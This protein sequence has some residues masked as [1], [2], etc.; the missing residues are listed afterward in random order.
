MSVAPRKRQSATKMRP[1]VKGPGADSCIAANDVRGCNTLFDHL[2]GKGEQ[3]V[4]HGKAERL[5][6]LEV[7]HQLELDWGLDG[8]LARFLALEDA[9]DIRRRSPKIIDQVSAIGQQTADFNEVTP[10]IECRET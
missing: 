10:R 7:D 1:V 9:I 3:L 2:V 8:E 4:G 6:G 5:C